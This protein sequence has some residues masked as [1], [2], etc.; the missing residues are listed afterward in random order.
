MSPTLEAELPHAQS[1]NSSHRHIRAEQSIPKRATQWGMRGSLG[2]LILVSACQKPAPPTTVVDAGL[3]APVAPVARRTP[4]SF[5]LHGE[6]RVDEYAWMKEKGT[7][8]LEAHLAAENAYTD[9]VLA[10]QAELRSALQKE[11]L[12]RL[13]KVIDDFPDRIRGYEYWERTEL[14]L[15]FNKLLRRPLD[16]GAEE[17]LLD[18]NTLAPGATYVDLLDFEVTDDDSR[19]AWAIDTSGS[20]DFSLHVSELDGGARWPFERNHV[21]SF[22][23][24]ADGKTLFFSTENEA[25]RSHMIH[26]LAPGDDAGVECFGEIDEHFDLTVR[27]S[28]GGR[29]LLAE[30]ISLTTTETLALDARTPNAAFTVVLP[31]VQDQRYL[32]D[33]RGEDFVIQSQDQGVEGRIFTVPIKNAKKGKRTEWVPRREGLP[34]EGFT[35]TQRHL[36]V[37]ERVEGQLR[38][39]A[40]EWSTKKSQDLGSVSGRY[41]PQV[42]ETPRSTRFLYG[43][44]SP[45]QPLT[46]FERELVSGQTKKRWEYPVNG[47]DSSRFEVLRL[48]ATA[49]DGTKIPITLARKKGTGP[50]APLLLDGYGAYGDPNDSGFSTWG[51]AL[52]ERGVVLAFAHVRGGG[53]FGDPWHDGGRLKTK[54]NSFTDFIACAEFLIAEKHTSPEKLAIT[55]MSAGGLLMGGVLNMRPELFHHAYVEVPFVDA[56]NTMLDTSLPLTVAEFEEW[57][58]PSK[59][60]EYAWMRAYSPY[61]NVKAQ[62]YPAI[63]VRSAYNDTQVLFHEPAKWVQRLRATKTDDRP[64]LLWM[65]MDPAGHGGRTALLDVA[66][67]E[68]KELAWLLTEWGLR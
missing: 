11:L 37:W 57:G 40:I 20:R 56:I 54:I 1:I 62:A 58:D 49:S 50:D 7:P 21:T 17:V 65:S 35:V 6:T 30:S 24:A 5:T 45:A 55:G 51:A 4:V 66:R 23:W 32:V 9:A 31:R 12:A 48:F 61:D 8:E 18:L 38:P 34:L 33:E 43:V 22:A 52:L 13:P 39:R 63:L 47:F 25:K 41:T 29:F 27:R 10:P 59:P 46:I 14:E 2:L 60:E 64:L 15:P 53:E 3:R 42:Q 16:G 68:S 36:V 26:R 67:D 19:L 28:E 44:D